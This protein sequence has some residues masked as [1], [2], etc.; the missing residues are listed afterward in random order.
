[1]MLLQTNID[2]FDRNL[3][4]TLILKP[5]LYPENMVLHC[6][7]TSIVKSF[8]CM[9]GKRI[10]KYSLISRGSIEIQLLRIMAYFLFKKI[11]ESLSSASFAA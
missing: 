10:N 2:V 1:M 8:K 6:M 4:N 5:Q 7:M 3:A 11:G 9:D